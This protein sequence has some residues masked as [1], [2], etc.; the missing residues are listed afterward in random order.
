[1]LTIHL[2][3]LHVTISWKNSSWSEKKI[4]REM[5][6]SKAINELD[7]MKVNYFRLI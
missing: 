1:M 3:S 6:Y 7:R 5:N 4:V 2:F